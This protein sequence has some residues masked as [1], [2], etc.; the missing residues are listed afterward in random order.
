M[1]MLTISEFTPSNMS[2][3]LTIS[4]GLRSDIAGKRSLIQT[5]ETNIEKLTEEIALKQN[6]LA[7][8]TETVQRYNHLSVHMPTCKHVRL[9]RQVWCVDECS[10]KATNR[11][12]H[13]Y[14][15]TLKEKA[16]S[17]LNSYNQELWAL[18]L[19]F[20]FLS[21]IFSVFIKQSPNNLFAFHQ[22]KCLKTNIQA[23]RKHS[24][25]TKNI[26]ANILLRKSFSHCRLKKGRLR[27][28]SRLMM[29]K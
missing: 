9:I 19:F 29:E 1:F 6:T 22:G 15:Q 20:L 24:S 8:H 3:S 14:E 16:D 7:R 28:G 4:K 12:L 25:H 10:I 23:V 27:E 17:Q 13:Q 2:K 11:R 21:C 5:L 26:T 18:S